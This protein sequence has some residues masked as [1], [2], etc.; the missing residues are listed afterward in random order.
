MISSLR[1]Y[2]NPHFDKLIIVRIHINSVRNKFDLLSEQFQESV[3]MLM[4]CETKIGNSFPNDQFQII[5]SNTPFRIDNNKNGGG[6]MIFIR[7]DISTKLLLM[8]KSNK[9][10]Y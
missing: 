4:I 3:N 5:G 1:K 8:D 10:L 7:E 6:M 2:R 9:S